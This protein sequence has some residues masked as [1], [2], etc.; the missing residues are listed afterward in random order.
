[1]LNG[2][3]DAGK[4]GGCRVT[5][6]LL[7]LPSCQA[8]L[9]LLPL[10]A[11]LRLLQAVLRLPP[12]CHAVL[13]LLPPQA[14]HLSRPHLIQS[15]PCPSELRHRCRSSHGLRPRSGSRNRRESEGQP[16]KPYCC[17]LCV[18]LQVCKLAGRGA[19][20][21]WGRP[22]AITCTHTYRGQETC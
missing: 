21:G 11:P 13:L 3:R 7:R 10:Q 6:H 18:E 8:L 20:T 17:S 19:T 14:L 15:H 2:G 9:L 5:N 12:L 16:P 22:H 4:G 1:M